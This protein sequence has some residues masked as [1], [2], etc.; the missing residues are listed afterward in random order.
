MHKDDY[1]VSCISNFVTLGA[2][3]LVLKSTEF[4]S[5]YTTTPI[6]KLRV[7]L[8]QINFVVLKFCQQ[9]T[10]LLIHTV[11][12]YQRSFSVFKYYHT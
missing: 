7:K 9:D 11:L 6:F 10:N 2:S 3:I 12:Q 4:I 8:F 5:C 1:T